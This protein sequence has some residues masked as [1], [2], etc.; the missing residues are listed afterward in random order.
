MR[1]NTKLYIV[2]TNNLLPVGTTLQDGRYRVER[3]LAS[4]GFGNTY[5]VTQ[6]KLN[7]QRAM[8]EFFMRGINARLEDGTVSVSNSDN[9]AAFDSQKKKFIREAE[10][11]A[12]FE[13]EHIVRV[14]DC[15]DENGTAYYV[16]DYINGCSLSEKLK[17]QGRPFTE[18]EAMPI[19]SQVLDALEAV[20]NLKDADGKGLLHLD[21]K[22]GNI[23]MNAEGHVWLIDFG[24]S[25][26]VSGNEGNLTLSSTMMMTPGYAPTEQVNH[27]TKAIGPWTDFYALGATLYKMLTNSTPPPS[28]DIADDPSALQLPS[29]ISTRTADLIRWLMQPT[30]S[31]RPRSVAEIRHFIDSSSSDEAQE[32][33]EKEETI[34]AEAV[35]D[36][37]K[38][39][40]TVIEETPT[41][42][43]PRQPVADNAAP[44]STEKSSSNKKPII[45]ACLILA[46]LIALF[47][48]R[49]WTKS[50]DSE[51]EQEMTE[52]KE[53]VSFLVEV[54]VPD[55][56]SGL[57]D[58]NP[59]S[60]RT[61]VLQTVDD[62]VT[63]IA[64]RL[65]E[66]GIRNFNV[67]IVSG[68][69]GHIQVQVPKNADL[70]NVRAA[71]QK[72]GTLEFWC[73]YRSADIAPYLQKLNNML[74]MSGGDNPLFSRLANRCQDN[75]CVVGYARDS[76]RDA[77]NRMLSS[78][79][80]RYI[81][82]NDLRLLWG[83]KP[84]TD[85]NF[86]ELY[87][88]Q[89]MSYNN[90]PEMGN[91]VIEKA[92]ALVDESQGPYVSMDMKTEGV[93]RWARMTRENTG[94]QIALVFDGLVYTAPIVNGEITN[95]RTMITG[96]FTEEE[97]QLFANLLNSGRMPAKT[98]IIKEE[99]FGN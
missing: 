64:T 1:Q 36:E 39:E 76:D 87:A 24:A 57:S 51:A 95:G 6:V 25:K 21:L 84:I 54:S 32:S 30:R 83:V 66:L 43:P 10:R 48:I 89:D 40:E 5:V 75:F 71:L 49:P 72:T 8:K 44:T 70:D 46:A 96:N 33:K 93:R 65:K 86:Y 88:I 92:E 20:H 12:A 34:I 16:M 35:D 23:M 47:I 59:D 55:I 29:T 94:R 69:D 9:S 52:L 98:K 11:L 19:F 2:E 61:K 15:F 45:I 31:Q 28:D 91:D 68:E 22:P 58:N 26:Q 42:V 53:G 82:P 90:L 7:K 99:S 97:T 3:Y 4:G 79:T 13:N 81:L 77:I 41:D 27:N 38:N 50:S 37:P 56:V 60:I 74:A 18:A 85:D 73:T 78:D 14:Q 67:E 80:A 62:C 17:S 63:T